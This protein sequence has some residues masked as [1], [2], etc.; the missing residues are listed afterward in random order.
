LPGKDNYKVATQV[1]RTEGDRIWSQAAID[2]HDI[3][4]T[5]RAASLDGIDMGQICGAYLVPAHEA[6]VNLVGTRC[7]Q[8]ETTMDEI[9]LTL[10]WIAEQCE[11][12]ERYQQEKFRRLHPNP[13]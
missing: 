7:E 13:Q 4:T 5:V 8:G 1:L 2:L 10:Y 9:R 12:N 6:L 11:M 3:V